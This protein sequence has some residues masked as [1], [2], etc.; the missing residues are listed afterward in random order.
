MS[1]QTNA[2][3]RA[4]DGSELLLQDNQSDA[5][6]LPIAGIER[7]HKPYPDK[8]DW[9]FEQTRIEAE[10]HRIE[11]RRINTFV[12]VERLAFAKE[13]CRQ[14]RIAADAGMRRFMDEAL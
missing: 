7:L 4:R 14:S 8:V 11:Q 1:R 10:N 5:L 9:L 3:V 2:R 6:L 12:F 13:C